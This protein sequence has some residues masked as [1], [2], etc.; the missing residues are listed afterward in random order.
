MSLEIDLI[1]DRCGRDLDIGNAKIDRY[2]T[3]RIAI[4]PC[5]NCLEIANTESYKKGMEDMKEELES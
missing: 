1:C 2:L 3:P 4:P 5:E